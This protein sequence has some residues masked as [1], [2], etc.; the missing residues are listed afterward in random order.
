[1]NLVFVSCQLGH[2]VNDGQLSPSLWGT[3]VRR[4]CWMV[5]HDIAGI[6]SIFLTQGLGRLLE[7]L[8]NG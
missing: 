6:N 2:P 5:E 7:V 3:G 1:M 8:V 4:R